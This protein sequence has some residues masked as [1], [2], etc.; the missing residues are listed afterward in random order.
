MT[1]SQVIKGMLRRVIAAKAFVLIN[2]MPP[3]SLLSDK[4]CSGFGCAKVGHWVCSCVSDGCGSFD[5]NTGVSFYYLSR[6][7]SV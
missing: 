6:P 5:S 7:L 1:A 3:A 2:N 4:E